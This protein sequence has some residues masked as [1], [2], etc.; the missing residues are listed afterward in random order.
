MPVSVYFFFLIKK[1][2]KKIKPA[3]LTAV[4]TGPHKKATKFECLPKMKLA[5]AVKYS[6]AKVR[7]TGQ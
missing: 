3:R 6:Q 7:L 2:N 1:S 4:R 5:Q